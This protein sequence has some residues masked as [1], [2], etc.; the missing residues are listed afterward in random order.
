MQQ[1]MQHTQ[2]YLENPPK[3]AVMLGIAVAIIV[4]STAPINMARITDIRTSGFLV[5][6][7]K[8]TPLLEK[9]KCL[10]LQRA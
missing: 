8:T 5:T 10:S 7:N 9:R 3:S 6:S 4:A 1:Q 2:L